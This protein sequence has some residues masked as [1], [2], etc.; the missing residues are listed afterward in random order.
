MCFLLLFSFVLQVEGDLFVTYWSYLVIRIIA[1]LF[2][3]SI[4]TLLNTAIIIAT[5]ETSS[6]RADVGRQLAWGAFGWFLFVTALGIFGV[7]SDI[8][9][10]VILC[11]ITW[12]TAAIIL[13]FAKNMPLSP[14]EWWWHT[15]SG[16]MA[17]PLSAIRKY[18]LEIAALTVVAVVLGA[19][20][21]VIDTYQPL[22]LL[23]LNEDNAPLAI[24]LAIAS[25]FFILFRAIENFVILTNALSLSLP[26]HDFV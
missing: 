23:N 8:T 25:K 26:R 11:I 2:P 22:H 20:W 13:V 14:P 7:H 16:M 1:D 9:A 18:G 21:S 6:G 15:K 4:I 3:V 10:P 19:F 5:R 12:I 24:K 17:I